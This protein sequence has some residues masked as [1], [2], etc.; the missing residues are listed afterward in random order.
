LH[1]CQAA[2]PSGTGDES[3][4][5]IRCG[6]VETRLCVRRPDR[7][8]RRVDRSGWR[9]VSSAGSGRTARL[10]APAG[11]AAESGGQHRDDRRL[12][13]NPLTF[14]VARS[15]RRSRG[16]HPRLDR[17]GGYG[18]HL[19]NRALLPPLGRAAGTPD[20]RIAPRRR[21][22]PH[23]RV[24][25]AQR[26]GTAATGRSPRRRGGRAALRFGGCSSVWASA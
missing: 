2:P 8:P 10:C 13:G 4:G 11:G 18:G 6:P 15:A 24:A 20:S 25:P 7:R 3:G 1:G 26:V 17:R 23:R 22:R 21:R 16:R 19:R 14:A 12:V 9:R 5:D